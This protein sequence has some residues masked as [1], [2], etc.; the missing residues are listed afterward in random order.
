MEGIQEQSRRLHPVVWAAAVSV[1]LFSV[2]GIGAITGLI[3]ASKSQPSAQQPASIAQTPPQSRTTQPPAARTAGGAPT[4]RVEYDR[5]GSASKPAAAQQPALT[6]AQPETAAHKPTK[7]EPVRYAQAPVEDRAP[8]L[9]AAEPAPAPAICKSCGVVSS[10]RTIERKGEGT[11]IGAVG[12]AVAGGVIGHQI[13][14]GR[15]RDVMTVVGAVA[16]G[17]GG[18]EVEKR[19]RKVVKHQVAVRF[20]DGHART[21]TYDNPPALRS[22]DRVRL[23]GGRLVPDNR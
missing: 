23:A 15:G 22:G 17:F 14:G 18:H 6:R 10:V 13:G 16:G 9:P 4:E 2:V 19:V 5:A 11:G 3:P 12:G 8:A 20:D 7:P 1:I 21:F